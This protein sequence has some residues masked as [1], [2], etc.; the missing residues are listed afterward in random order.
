MHLD[1]NDIL[2]SEHGVAFHKSIGGRHLKDRFSVDV[3]AYFVWR[4]RFY[5]QR[6]GEAMGSPLNS[7]VANY[8]MEPEALRTARK[9]SGNTV[10][11]N[12]KLKME[13]EANQ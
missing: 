9:C 7:M 2:V 8:F 1:K 13:K 6:D 12:I 11:A 5:K 3:V 4:D 10:S